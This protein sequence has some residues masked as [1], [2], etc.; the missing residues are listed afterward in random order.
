[1]RKTNQYKCYTKSHFHF[2]KIK[3]AKIIV[4]TDSVKLFK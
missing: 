3:K 2:D 1:M 4:I